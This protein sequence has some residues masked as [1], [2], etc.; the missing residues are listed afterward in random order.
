[1]SATERLRVRQT[2]PDALIDHLATV[3]R[4]ILP[5]SAVN[6]SKSLVGKNRRLQ[7][8]LGEIEYS[9]QQ[10]GSRLVVERQSVAGG[11]AVGM[12]D[13]LPASRWPQQL[14]I[15]IANGVD[16]NGQDWKAVLAKL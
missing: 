8:R 1:M 16:A 15:D 4:P 12:K 3:L 11:F 6:L 14:V 13:V 9:F 10:D 7:V 5:R 2:S